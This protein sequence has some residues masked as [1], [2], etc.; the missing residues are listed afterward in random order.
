MGPGAASGDHNVRLD[1]ETHRLSVKLD[2]YLCFFS[3]QCEGDTE[4]SD[5]AVSH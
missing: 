3:V 4:I 2:S 5:A 1:V